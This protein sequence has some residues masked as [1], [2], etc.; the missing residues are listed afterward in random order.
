VRT[1]ACHGDEQLTANQLC[2]Q[3]RQQLR[4]LSSRTSSHLQRQLCQL[5]RCLQRFWAGLLSMLFRQ[6]CSPAPALGFAGPWDA[7]M[8]FAASRRPVANA[9][10]MV[11]G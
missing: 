1:A 4:A 8:M 6:C 7:A 11:A 10:C 5:L 3:E 2:L 9:P